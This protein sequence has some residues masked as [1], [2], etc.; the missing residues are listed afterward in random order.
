[1][2]AAESGKASA[3]S[4][5]KT[6]MIFSSI[7]IQM[8]WQPQHLQKGCH[9]HTAFTPKSFTATYPTPAAQKPF[10]LPSAG[11]RLTASS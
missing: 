5:R 11:G 3:K 8:S 7:T 9:I 2:Q 10:P 6:G 4:W 1:V